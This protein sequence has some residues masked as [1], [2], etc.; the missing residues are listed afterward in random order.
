MIVAISPTGS[1]IEAKLDRVVDCCPVC[2]F[3]GVMTDFQTAYLRFREESTSEKT[4]QKTYRCPRHTCGAL[5]IAEYDDWD[6]ARSDGKW[7]LKR[8]YPKEMVK[9]TL[10]SAIAQISPSFQGLYAQALAAQ[11]HGLDDVFGMALRKALEFLIKDYCISKD[12]ASAPAIKKEFLGNTIK[13]RVTD[14]NIKICAERAVWLGNDETHYE[15]RW[16]SHDAS[17]LDRLIKLT[18]NWIDNEKTTEAYLAAMN[19]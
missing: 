19:P 4:L 14:P 12:P 13:N 7:Y 11:H 2:N 6:P 10:P 8:V 1:K 16:T 9:P 18:I 17:D 3:T 5:F 15:R